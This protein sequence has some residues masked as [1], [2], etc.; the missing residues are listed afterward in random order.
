MCGINI[1]MDK[2][3]G[4]F[5]EDRRT[6]K[7]KKKKDGYLIYHVPKSLASLKGRLDPF[8]ALILVGLEGFF[9]LVGDRVVGEGVNVIC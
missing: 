6:E 2:K 4:C 3:H 8:D 1:L 5:V 9:N 7:N